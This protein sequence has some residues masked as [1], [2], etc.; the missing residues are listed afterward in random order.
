MHL[1]CLRDVRRYLGG[2]DAPP[3]GM[4]GRAD[5]LFH[6]SCGLLS[7]SCDRDGKPTG[8][9]NIMISCILLMEK[10]TAPGRDATLR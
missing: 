1:V 8:K 9:E 4:G 10:R 6:P 2:T 7:R 5:I 3:G